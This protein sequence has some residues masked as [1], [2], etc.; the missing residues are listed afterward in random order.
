[1]SEIIGI[2]LGTT[3]SM[4]AIVDEKGAFIV[5]D[6]QL[7]SRQPS[8]V[9]YQKEQVFV[10]KEALQ[11]NILD[12]ENCFF[13]FK[14][15]MGKKYQDFANQKNHFTYSI[16][17]G[18]KGEILLGKKKINPEQLSAEVLKKV[19]K[20]TE[21]ILQKKIKQAV[22]T[23]PAYFDDVQ[24][25]ATK[26]AAIIAGLEV[27][28]I[29]NEPTAAAIAYGLDKKQQGKVAVFDFGGGTFDIS[30]LEFKNKVFRVLVTHGNSRLGGDDIDHLLV[31]YIKEKYKL[32]YVNAK[33]KS[34]L[35]KIAEETKIFLSNHL[36]YK[37]EFSLA[38]K[39]ISFLIT[40]EQFNQII[41]PIV[42][43]TI[44][45]TKMAMQDA[46]LTTSEI[47][48]IVL[49]G[50]STKTPLV[51]KKVTDFFGKA[52]H[53]KIDPDTVVAVGA[54]I[55]GHLLAGKR[56]DF[57]LIDIIPLSL[58]I[59]TLNGVFS[60]LLL[61]NSSIPCKVQETFSTQ[62]D[63][64]TAVVINIYQGE[65]ELVKDCR[66]LGQFILKNIPP[67]PAGLPRIEVEF[68]VDTNGLL[69]VSAKE[70]RSGVDTQIE[71][72][73]DQ[74]LTHTQI[75]KMVEDSIIHAEQDFLESRLQEFCFQAKNILAALEK[76]WTLAEKFFSSKEYEKVKNQKKLLEELLV[77]KNPLAIK[78]ASD[79]LGK[80]TTE[81]A[82]YLIETNLKNTNTPI[83]K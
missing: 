12:V 73:P 58:G 30:I 68:F 65:R 70:L 20:I 66:F 48:S 21:I 8:I 19:K 29:I 17:A 23:V 40:L 63:N 81:F 51:R 10:G 56:R 62:K 47:A 11:N 64:Q 49:V 27:T 59:E 75:E 77:Q 43:K 25:Q 57:L 18:E 74:G 32:S 35:K 6:E 33:E 13:S 24:R 44:T 52:P 61:K 72:I 2:D 80:L 42:E 39:K 69:K 82:N 14:P 79:E 41:T 16:S 3:N 34:Y 60:K 53:L 36:E 67:M 22:I 38:T 50:G 46:K 28:R 26:Q 9:C 45:H 37:K 83:K 4:A 55:Q 54:A 31:Q 1:M 5:E 7:S 15:L 76:S 78:E 71:I